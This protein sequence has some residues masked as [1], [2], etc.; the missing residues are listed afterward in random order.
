LI[1]AVATSHLRRSQ[2]SSDGRLKGNYVTPRARAEKATNG[3]VVSTFKFE[4]SSQRKPEAIS[5]ISLSGCRDNQTVADTV[6]KGMAVGAM[7]NV[8]IVFR[9]PGLLRPLNSFLP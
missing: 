4:D 1:L 7:S 6:N 9:Q 3:T 5:Q 8:R 2:Y